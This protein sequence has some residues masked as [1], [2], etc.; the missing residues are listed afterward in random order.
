MIVLNY[1]LVIE[2]PILLPPPKVLSLLDS[3]STVAVKGDQV[4]MKSGMWR[5]IIKQAPGKF[6]EFQYIVPK[7]STADLSEKLIGKIF[8][9][10]GDH[11]FMISHDQDATTA[12]LDE[13]F[14][15]YGKDIFSYLPEYVDV[16]DRQVISTVRNYIDKI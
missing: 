1:E 6:L 13:I 4:E 11:C 15:V 3:S 12:L 8:D 2:K 5:T 16:V 7:P 10:I 9:A 14:A